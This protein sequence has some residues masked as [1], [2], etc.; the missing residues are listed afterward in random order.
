[1]SI[2][3]LESINKIAAIK[4]SFRFLLTVK[5][6]IYIVIPLDTSNMIDKIL[7]AI[8]QEVNIFIGI[9]K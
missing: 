2:S 1:M 5:A 6:K 4:A 9:T 3:G 7:I 8:G